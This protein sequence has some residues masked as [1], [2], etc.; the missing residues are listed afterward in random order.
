MNSK[1]TKMYI[2]ILVNLVTSLIG[3]IVWLIS[4]DSVKMAKSDKSTATICFAV[5]V[6]PAVLFYTLWYLKGVKAL[7]S[8]TD[9]IPSFVPYLVLSAVISVAL[10]VGIGFA[11]FDKALIYAGIAAV[12]SVIGSLVS[13]LALHP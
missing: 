2:G 9:K 7:A 3:A 5:I 1:N 4:Q 12:A 6:I 8:A 11:L 13:Y 10:T